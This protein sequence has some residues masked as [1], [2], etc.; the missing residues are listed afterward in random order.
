MVLDLEFL[1]AAGNIMLYLI[2]RAKNYFLQKSATLLTRLKRDCVCV[3]LTRKERLK[4]IFSE[5]VLAASILLLSCVIH[6]GFLM[7]LKAVINTIRLM[8]LFQ[9]I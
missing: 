4:I 6:T 2:C 3:M 7:F 5:A 1:P 8:F 9:I